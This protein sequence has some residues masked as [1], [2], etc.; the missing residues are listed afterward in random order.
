MCVGK[1][2]AGILAYVIRYTAQ[3]AYRIGVVAIRN[4]K[5]DCKK[6][7]LKWWIKIDFIRDCLFDLLACS[8]IIQV[9]KAWNLFC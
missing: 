5:D 2:F 4:D 1:G 6:I 7:Y 8:Y 3:Y 9:N